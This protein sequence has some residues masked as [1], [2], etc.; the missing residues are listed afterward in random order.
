MI[1]RLYIDNFRTFQNFEWK[2]GAV[3][4]V[5]GRNG[6][7]KS[8][9]FEVLHLLQALICG[10]QPVGEMFPSTSLVRWEKRTSQQLELDVRSEAGSFRYRITI[11][12]GKN[13]GDGRISLETLH[14]DDTPLFSFKAG[15]IQLFD[16]S[17]KSGPEFAGN[18]KKSGLGIVVPGPTN[19][20][21]TWFKQWLGRLL[22]LRPDPFLMT[23]LT[24]SE[25]SFLWPHASNFANWYRYVL[26]EHGGKV[27][28]AMEALGK[29]LDGFQDLSIRVDEQRT[30]WLRANFLDPNGKGYT[31][32]FD[33]LSEGQ[34]VLILLYIA[35]FTQMDGQRTIAFDEPDNFVSLDEIQPF[36]MEMLDKALDGTGPQCFIASHHPEYLNQLAPSH[37]HVLFRERGGQTRIRL[38]EANEALSASEIVARGGLSRIP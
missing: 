15:Q 36:L 22:V 9:L 28:R 35:L 2:P 38:F 8:T 29:V 31:L 18:S 16:D 6:T 26:Q 12:Q 7:G 24:P 25:N 3:A 4:L 33:E 30:G 27:Y 14:L 21:L 37:G 17:G 19:Q 23:G 1:E 5:M 10:E 34:R 11:E 32:Q 20:R 13:R